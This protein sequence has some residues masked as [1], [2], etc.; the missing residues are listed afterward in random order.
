M[1]GYNMIWTL[2][3]ALI[4]L[5]IVQEVSILTG[6]NAGT[7]DVAIT[8]S[9]PVTGLRHLRAARSRTSKGVNC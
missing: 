7:L 9:S 5:L 2:I 8:I 6:V 1:Y 3:P 4:V